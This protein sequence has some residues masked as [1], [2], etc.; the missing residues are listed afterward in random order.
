[1]P[2]RPVPVTIAAAIQALE[3]LVVMGAGAYVGWETVVG[4]PRE[5]TSAVALAVTAVISGFLM[6]MVGRGLLRLDRWSRSPSAVTQIFVF[7]VAVPMVRGGEY[8]TGVP[9]VA[10]AAVGLVLLLT[11][12]AG[13][14]LAGEE[15]SGDRGD[16]SGEPD[17]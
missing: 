14:A 6:V 16:T 3:G 8:A 5:L 15:P 13:R 11:P 7:I 17:A 4:E 12:A 1:M 2:A 9:L 10:A